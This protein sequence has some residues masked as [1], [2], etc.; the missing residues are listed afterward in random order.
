LYI[1]TSVTHL[2]LTFKSADGGILFSAVLSQCKIKVLL[3]RKRN[4]TGFTVMNVD[5]V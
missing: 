1:T 4:T 2:Q 5:F 3:M